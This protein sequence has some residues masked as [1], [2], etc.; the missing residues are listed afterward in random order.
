M[1]TTRRLLGLF[2]TYKCTALCD[3]CCVNSGPGR[4]ER[5]TREEM[6]SYIGQAAKLPEFKI[7][8]FTGG[9]P[10][11]LYEDLLAAIT[12]AKSLG[13]PSR[14][15]TNSYW[16]TTPEAAMEKLQP[17][18]EAGL[19]EL[20]MSLDDYHTPYVPTDNV[21]HAFQAARQLGLR[22]A[23][24]TAEDKDS[25][26]RNSNAHEF[27]GISREDL[28]HRDEFGQDPEAKKAW[29]I[30]S[31]VVPVA[32]AARKIPLRRQVL[33]EAF[34][35]ESLRGRGCGLVFSQFTVRPSGEVQVCC[36]CGVTSAKQFVAGN[37]KT[38]PL[39]EIIA[40]AEDDLLMNWVAL[41]GPYSIADFVKQKRPE[42]KFRS[43]YA[44]ICDMC[45]ELFSR[46]DTAEVLGKHA[47]E[48]AGDIAFRSQL[49]VRN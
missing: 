24:A 21:A 30:D 33:P 37:L 18:A 4:E 28:L 19:I 48:K 2:I 15:V 42:L 23:V 12:Y 14:I 20:N 40:A 3:S 5:M 10:F 38:Q 13:L 34:S 7:I 31:P 17:L 25:K 22:V 43:N 9:E 11:L 45:V 46:K 1:K 44:T 8:V 32:R 29:L 47:G 41:D 39:T 16:A 6:F 35:D 26:I 49:V 27:L 36:G